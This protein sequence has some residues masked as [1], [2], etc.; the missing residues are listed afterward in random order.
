MSDRLFFGLA[1]LAAIGLIALALVW[2]PRAETGLHEAP[3]AAPAA[4]APAGE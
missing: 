2:P 4:E 1:A 3:G